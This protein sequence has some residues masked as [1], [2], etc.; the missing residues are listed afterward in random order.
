[1]QYNTL[2]HY[3]AILFWKHKNTKAKRCLFFIY[4]LACLFE[5][6]RNAFIKKKPT[7]MAHM[8]AIYFDVGFIY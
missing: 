6:N 8:V 5:N 2:L 3:F 1:M 4:V 7:D